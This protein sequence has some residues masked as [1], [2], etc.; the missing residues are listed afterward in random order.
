MLV[1]RLGALVLLVGLGFALAQTLGLAVVVASE[2]YESW[3]PALAVLAPAAALAA[4]SAALVLARRPLGTRLVPAV[5]ALVLTTGALAFVEA[6]PLG[7]FLEDYERAALARGVEVPEYRRDQ[8]W[9][10][11][12][13]VEERTEEFRSQGALG[14]LAVV[15]VYAFLVRGRSRPAR[16]PRRGAAR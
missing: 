10:E 6:P 3:I 16:T 15:G 13:Y 8:G 4:A 1:P 14:A 7:R 2:G 12:R 5:A 9:T 11:R